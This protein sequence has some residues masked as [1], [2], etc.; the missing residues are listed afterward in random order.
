MV[1]CP[2]SKI[3]ILLIDR[4]PGE[5]RVAVLAGDR[6]VE[7]YHHRHGIPGAGAIYQ[8]RVGKP[9]SGVNSVFVEIGL[10]RP[11]LMPC[12]GPPPPEGSAVYVRIVQ[13][14]R[15]DK[16]AKVARIDK[17]ALAAATGVESSQSTAPMC[18]VEAEHPVSFC[19][20][21]YGGSIVHAV[22]TPHDA[23]GRITALSG[24]LK[25]RLKFSSAN[26][27]AEHGVDDTIEG[28]L[29]PIAPFAGGGKLIIEPTAAFTAVD[30][31]AGP[32]TAA[33]ANAAA[34]DA[35]ARELRL[36][37]IAGPVIVDLIPSKGRSSLIDRFKRAVADDP[38]PTQVSGLT[39]EGRLEINRRR[40]RPSLVDL[41]LD[42]PRAGAPSLE[43]VAFDALRRCVRAGLSTGSAK[44]TLSAQ[45][46]VIGALR[47]PLRSA[48]D[49]AESMLKSKVVLHVAPVSRVFDIDIVTS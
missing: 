18:V 14:P 5:T 22:V 16:G 38:V 32:M 4:G 15:S 20:R 36:R 26:L 17:A 29:D 23:D 39:P 1:R 8:G 24:T 12:G 44:I 3:D 40:S 41:L 48:L 28:A 43:S 34:I 37:A 7:I 10:D 42:N 46:A 33:D 6:V 31:D 2:V 21:L 47:G 35:L 9:L 27:F 49:E 45:D 30:V 11:A 25:C 19:A 13:P